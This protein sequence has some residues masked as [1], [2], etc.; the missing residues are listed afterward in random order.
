MQECT[1]YAFRSKKK[2]GNKVEI[3]S[4]MLLEEAIIKEEVNLEEDEKEN[5]V[6]EEDLLHVTIVAKLVTK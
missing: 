5:L 1:F 6:E 2:K 3:H 4:L